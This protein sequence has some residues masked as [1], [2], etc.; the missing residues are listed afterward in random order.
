MWLFLQH[1]VGK[2]PD[3]EKAKERYAKAQKELDEREKELDSLHAQLKV[4]S[5]DQ[6]AKKEDLSKTK[7]DLTETISRSLTP[8]RMKAVREDEREEERPSGEPVTSIG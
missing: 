5:S 8:P 7:I 6:A 1:L 4:V 3:Y 2:S